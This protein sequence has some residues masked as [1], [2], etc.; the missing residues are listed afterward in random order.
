MC[1][2]DKTPDDKQ[3]ADAGNNDMPPSTAIDHDAGDG[4]NLKDEPNEG[5]PPQISHLAEPS[6]KNWLDNISKYSIAV[7]IIGMFTSG[8]ST[9]AAWRSSDAAR[10][11]ART[12][13]ATLQISAEPHLGV[14][15]PNFIPISSSSSNEKFQPL[16]IKNTGH[17]AAT[18]RAVAVNFSPKTDRNN[19]PPKIDQ[20]K[21]I[22]ALEQEID[23]QESF[24][25]SDYIDKYKNTIG[26]NLDNR[27]F[28]FRVLVNYQDGAGNLYYRYKCEVYSR[29]EI[30]YHIKTMCRH[31]NATVKV[32]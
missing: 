8:V 13:E 7:S 10:T 26:N 19:E 29:D 15:L 16:N 25:T 18:I 20:P 4:Q 12:A 6:K 32:K 1:D 28:F 5:E 27:E 31:F 23:E 3:A 9:W 14:I 21:F 2:H 11:S 24:T 22:D 17:S 30:G